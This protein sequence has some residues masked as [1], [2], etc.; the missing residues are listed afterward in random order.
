MRSNV[1][2]DAFSSGQVGSKLWLCE[3]LEKI[4]DRIDQILEQGNVS[5][6]L[7]SR[8]QYNQ[9]H[10]RNILILK[11]QLL[12]IEDILLEI[13]IMYRLLVLLLVC[14]SSIYSKYHTIKR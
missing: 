13:K 7:I 1:D 8:R 10:V 2:R 9:E 11:Y 14:A 6:L 12:I 5:I 4:F 3:E